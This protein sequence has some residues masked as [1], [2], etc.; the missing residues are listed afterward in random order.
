MQARGFLIGGTAGRTT[1]AGEG[2]Q[3]QDGHSHILASTI[4]NCV[5]YDPTFAYELAVILQDGLRRMYEEQENVF[6]YI[7]CMNENY[8]HP[9]MPKGAEAGILKGLY[10]FRDGGKGKI[11]VQLMGCGTILREVIAA[12]EL[13]EHEFEI[14]AD[15]WSVTSFNELRR[16]AL[17]IDRHNMLHPDRKPRLSFIE[18]CLGKQE[19][20]FVAATDYMKVFADQVRQWIPGRYTVLGTDGFGRS[21]SREQLR[22]FFEVDRYNIVVAALKSLADEGKIDSKT[23]IDA[24]ARYDIDPGKPDPVT[25]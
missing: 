19:G 21:D 22:R 20:P 14:P 15:I 1:L 13:L 7:T 4:P 2:L 17:S 18:E 9:A 25:L 12:A 16:D 5:T 10:K 3:H 24:M 23:V 6:Y 11:R 8:K